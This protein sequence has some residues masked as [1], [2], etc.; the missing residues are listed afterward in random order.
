MQYLSAI[1][2]LTCEFDKSMFDEL[3]LKGLSLGQNFVRN[4]LIGVIV[5]PPLVVT[6]EHGLR[7]NHVELNPNKRAWTA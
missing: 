6:D 5:K 4:D 2:H 7:S 3:C 1:F